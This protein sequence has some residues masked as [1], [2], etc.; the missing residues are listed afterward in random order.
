VRA[1][2]A[3]NSTARTSQQTASAVFWVQSEMVPFSAAAR[4]AAAARGNGVVENARLFAF[5][6]MAAADALI[7]GFEAKYKFSFWRPITAIRSGAPA[8]NR[9]LVADPD[10]EPLITTPGH[11]EYP[12]AHCLASGAMEEVL[13]AFFGGDKV[14]VTVVYPA[15]G[16]LRHYT[17]FSQM[18][19]EVVDA[20]VWS[21]THYRS[22]D[23]Q[24]LALGRKVAEYGMSRFLRPLKSGS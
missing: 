19:Q 2:G 24:G 17:S 15:P 21:G 7:S 9:K 5:L 1:Y 12:S 4:A 16:I 10:W 23:E 8:L 18:A 14:D 3:K 6:S 11:P 20:R 13:R 22:A